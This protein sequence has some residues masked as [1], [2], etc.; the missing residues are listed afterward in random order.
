MSSQSGSRRTSARGGRPTGGSGPGRAAGRSSARAQRAS[1]VESRPGAAERRGTSRPATGSGSMRPVPAGSAT[2]GRPS[3]VASRSRPR[4]TGRAAILVIVLAVLAV[5]YASSLRAYLQQRSHIESLEGTITERQGQIDELE[6]EKQRW[7]DPE[8]VETEARS[9]LGLV[10]PGET[11]FVAL[12]DGLPLEPESS[13]TDP[14]DVGTTELPPAWW[15]EA[16]DSVLVAGDP[17]RRADPPPL[18]R[19]DEPATDGSE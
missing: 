15:D 10:K 17:Q 6:R 8:F 12:R 5:S 13:L 19:I 16:W 18:T 2:R 4:F 14:A 11:P 1:A 3:G 7:Q 9:R